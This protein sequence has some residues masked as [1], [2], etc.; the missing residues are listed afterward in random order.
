VRFGAFQEKT[1]AKPRLM[2]LGVA[3]VVLGIVALSA[4]PAG[5]QSFRLPLPQPG[6]AATMAKPLPD[7][8]AL[9][10][11]R[12]NG[13][14]RMLLAQLKAPADLTMYKDFSDAG[15]RDATDYAGQVDLP[16]GYWVYVYPYWYIWRDRDSDNLTKRAYGPEQ[17]VG[18][19]DSPMAGDSSAAWCSRS[20]DDQDEWLLLE[21]AEPVTPAIVLIYANYNPGSV[22]KV[23]AFRLDG[24]E[25]EL[26]SG[27][28]P[29]P[30]D[31]GHG[32]SVIPVQVDFKANRIK[33]YLNSIE[34]PSWNE[35]D[36]VGVRDVH[37]AT[38][39][40]VAAEASTTYAQQPAIYI[41]GLTP[42]VP[43]DQLMERIQS[44]ENEVKELKELLKSRKM[45]SEVRELKE[46][47]KDLK[48]LLQK[49]DK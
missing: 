20:A 29:T 36:T 28:D 25:V 19:P 16:K 35:I 11:A 26:W 2:G 42:A 12:V 33:V 1:M 15:R 18:P 34:T 17:L 44:L 39:W 23:S 27:E 47:V 10:K 38:H 14:Y 30:T 37:G 32:V 7:D 43:N 22:S 5:S 45:E 49:K 46:L 6:A 48:E 40:P 41:N 8:E 9:V 24:T 3:A 21:Y 13:K 4:W 31:S